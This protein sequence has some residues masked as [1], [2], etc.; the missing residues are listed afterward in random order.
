MTSTRVLSIIAICVGLA[1]CNP[2]G[3]G[4][5]GAAAAAGSL[6]GAAATAKLQASG[7]QWMMQIRSPYLKKERFRFCCKALKS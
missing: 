4:D 6:T 3:G 7:W 1:A 5:P 2:F